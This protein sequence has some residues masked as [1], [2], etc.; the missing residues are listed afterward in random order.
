MQLVLPSKRT[1]GGARLANWV[2][3][4]GKMGRG[5]EYDQRTKGGKMHDFRYNVSFV[6]SKCALVSLYQPLVA[7]FIR[8]SQVEANPYPSVVD[9]GYGFMR[10]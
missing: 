7:V 5:E 4:T 2:V 3:G 9:E 6:G 1:R 10:S 8:F